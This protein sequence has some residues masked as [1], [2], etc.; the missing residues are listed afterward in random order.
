M[1]KKP[2]QFIAQVFLCMIWKVPLI[3]FSPMPAQNSSWTWCWNIYMYRLTTNNKTHLKTYSI[4]HIEPDYLQL[5]STAHMQWQK[6]IQYYVHV[7]EYIEKSAN[8]VFL[9]INWTFIHKFA[10]ICIFAEVN[11]C[12]IAE[13]FLFPFSRKWKCSATRVTAFFFQGFKLLLN[14]F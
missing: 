5:K 3:S 13:L 11:C 8:E 1:L 10:L 4:S 7:V 9:K 6:V 2:L 14:Y 12:Y